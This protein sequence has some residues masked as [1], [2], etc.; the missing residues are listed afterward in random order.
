MPAL[1]TSLI[2]ERSGREMWNRRVRSSRKRHQCEVGATDDHHVC[3]QVAQPLARAKS[4]CNLAECSYAFVESLG[5]HKEAAFV[6][7]WLLLLLPLQFS[8]ISLSVVIHFANK[9][10]LTNNNG[11]FC[12]LFNHP[13]FPQIATS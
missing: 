7:R 12:I 11:Y 2:E 6:N 10:L 9:M 8:L 5:H 4:G 3:L 13:I 1:W